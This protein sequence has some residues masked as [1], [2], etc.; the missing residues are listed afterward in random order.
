MEKRDDKW[1]VGVFLPKPLF[2]DQM[3]KLR[4]RE[5]CG[6]G[7]GGRVSGKGCCGLLIIRSHK[8]DTQRENRIKTDKRKCRDAQLERPVEIERKPLYLCQGCMWLSDSVSWRLESTRASMGLDSTSAPR[9]HHGERLSHSMYWL[10]S[11]YIV[12]CF[13][14]W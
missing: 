10:P 1:Y 9:P 3:G 7:G 6:G 13:L 2:T 11:S 5:T 14:L 4:P 8:S 12:F